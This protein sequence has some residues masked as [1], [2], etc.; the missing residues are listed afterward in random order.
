MSE[1]LSHTD[2]KRAPVPGAFQRDNTQLLSGV[3]AHHAA[4]LLSLVHRV[5]G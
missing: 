2:L 5:S 1:K 4:K 3:K